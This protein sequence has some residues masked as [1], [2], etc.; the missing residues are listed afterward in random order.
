MPTLTSVNGSLIVAAE[1]YCRYA[2][3]A[4]G[5]TW[6]HDVVVDYL[7]NVRHLNQVHSAAIVN[8][9]KC[10]EHIAATKQALPKMAPGGKAIWTESL[11]Y[12]EAWRD[13][14]QDVA[15]EASV[16]LGEYV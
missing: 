15:D 8:V 13:T 10:S 2:L 14:W 6:P 16:K 7:G 4:I 1:H 9:L 12:W 3:P 11:A 5:W